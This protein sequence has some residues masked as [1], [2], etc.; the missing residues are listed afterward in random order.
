MV[1]DRYQHIRHHPEP[2][3]LVEWAAA[4]PICP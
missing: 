2:A 1:T 4:E 3:D